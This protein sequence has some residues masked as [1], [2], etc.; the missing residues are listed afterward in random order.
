MREALL[1]DLID[2]NSLTVQCHLCY[3]HCTLAPG[4]T[5]LCHVRLNDH[6]VLRSLVYGKLVSE[7]IDPIE[8]KPLFHFLPSTLSYSIATVG[9]NFRC[10]HCQNYQISQY[11]GDSTGDVPGTR[12]TPAQVVNNALDTG[13]RS[14]SYTYIEPTVFFEFA[15]ET[16]ELAH[17]HNLKNV[18][19]SNGYTT[20]PAA[21]MIAPFL[22]ANN[23]DLKS[24]SDSFYRRICNARLAPVLETIQLMR[25]LGVWVEIT[26]LIIPDLNDSSQELRSIAD[27]LVSLDP[28]IP[29]HVSRFHPTYKLT[30]HPPTPES[31]LHRAF[32]IGKTA[33]LKHIYIGNV[34][35][36][37]GED[38]YCPSCSRTV[39]TRSGYSIRDTQIT[40]GRC[41]ACSAPIAGV[42]S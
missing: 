23:I 17:Q 6:G 25:E 1:Y 32:D 33:G 30:D 4:K 34:H 40:N 41:S 3:H 24:F 11:A 16:A 14:I 13:C 8:K 5:G 10:R 22:D 29:W 21:K 15:L 36:G 12:R 28:E 39:V 18:F 7:H 9:C 31:T 2:P 38:T 42:W 20:P 26:T 35:G 27:F 37:G 19:V